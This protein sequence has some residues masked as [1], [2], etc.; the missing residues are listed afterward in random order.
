MT[1]SVVIPVYNTAPYLDACIASVLGQGGEDVEI[2]CVDDGS[3][4]E[5]ATVL[6]KWNAQSPRVRVVR[7]DNAGQGAARNRGIA[8]ARGEFLL[9]VDSDDVLL[10]GAIA[11]LLREVGD[12]QV[13]AF[14]HMT[15][16]GSAPVSQ[17]ADTHARVVSREK[18][19][20]AMGVVWNKM[21][22]REWWISHGIRF[23][24]KVIFEDI[25]VHWQLVLL[26]ERIV[27][28][29]STLYALRVRADSTTGANAATPR[30]L[31]SV[32]AHDEVTVLFRENPS[33]APYERVHLEI[34]LQ[35]LAGCVDALR[36]AELVVRGEL[37][38]LVDGRLAGVDLSP[39]ALP[40]LSTRER[41]TLRAFQG[42][43]PSILRR[44]C[45]LV[46]RA[47]AR[48]VRRIFR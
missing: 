3:T 19:L 45:F 14:D 13:V 7:Q 24:E 5:S 1:I 35:N 9:F 37:G 42:H 33:W 31:E 17:S 36:D 22:R 8:E 11:L 28:I 34:M 26:P 23:K 27:Y 46:L 29:P 16:S 47:I 38:R 41:D 2:I 21:V 43:L 39:V 6:A 25:P 18:L 44:Q 30:R 4:D 15:F 32:R 10:P 40:G 48:V 12:A 20:R